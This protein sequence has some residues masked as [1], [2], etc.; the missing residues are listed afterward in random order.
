M[1]IDISKIPKNLKEIKVSDGRPAYIFVPYEGMFPTKQNIKGKEYC[2]Y[3]EG[4]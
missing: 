3:C 4:E 1:Y 2:P